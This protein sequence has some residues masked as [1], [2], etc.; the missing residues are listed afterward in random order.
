MPILAKLPT[1]SELR[2]HLLTMSYDTVDSA[3]VSSNLDGFGAICFNRMYGQATN[4]SN[5]Y[6]NILRQISN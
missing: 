1:T 2:D 6:Q 4:V 3:N 5:S